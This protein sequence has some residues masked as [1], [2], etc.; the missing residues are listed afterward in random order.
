MM[1]SWPISFWEMRRS[2]L[3]QFSIARE[4]GSLADRTLQFRETS[5]LLFL[6][7]LFFCSSFPYNSISIWLFLFLPVNIIIIV[8]VVIAE[9]LKGDSL[10]L[11]LQLEPILFRESGRP[12]S[13][14]LRDS[15]IHLEL[16]LR[17]RN[18][19]FLFDFFILMHRSLA[20]TCFMPAEL[21]QINNSRAGRTLRCFFPASFLL[22][23]LWLFLNGNRDWRKWLR[24]VLMRYDWWL[25]RR[26]FSVKV[27]VSSAAIIVNWESADMNNVSHSKSCHCLVGI[28]GPHQH[29][30]VCGIQALSYIE[31]INLREYQVEREDVADM[32]FLLLQ[33]MRVSHIRKSR[34]SSSWIT[35]SRSCIF[36]IKLHSATLECFSSQTYKFGIIWFLK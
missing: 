8:A 33:M 17:N 5:S 30:K 27:E 23:L 7:L 36:L 13:Q 28:P 14:S 11:L 31:Q 24:N 9:S 26:H 10:L 22:L 2:M 21:T 6:H 35:W 18:M 34:L 32:F 19:S 15:L 12:F 20:M 16:L 4:A 29:S 25:L 1:R 3:L